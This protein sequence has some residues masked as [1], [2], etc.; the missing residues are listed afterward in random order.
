MKDHDMNIEM[1]R[2]FAES[3]HMGQVRKDAAQTPYVAH[4]AEVAGLVTGFGGTPS[5]IMAAWLHDTVEDCDVQPADLSARFGAHVA[6]LVMEMTDDKS[7]DYATRKQVQV[8]QA[9]HKSPEGMLIKICDKFANVRS[10][11]DSEPV[12]WTVARQ[13]AYLDWAESVVAGLPAGAEVAKAA[14]AA[15]LTVSRR[16]VA[17]RSARAA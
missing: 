6:R 4:L 5:A 15:Q 16:V 17:A 11:A 12:E 7:L 14:F 2:S 1:A 3:A 13:A 10:V 8:A 9:P